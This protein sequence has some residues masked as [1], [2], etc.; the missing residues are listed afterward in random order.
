MS[1]DDNVRPIA[2]RVCRNEILTGIDDPLDADRDAVFLR[3]GVCDLLDVFNPDRVGP[4]D[5]VLIAANSR[6][7]ALPGRG[8]RCGR[9]SRR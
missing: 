3:V 8:G 6:C 4:N 1:T 9:F 7:G 2:R 5:E